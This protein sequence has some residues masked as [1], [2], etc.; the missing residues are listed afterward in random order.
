MNKYEISYIYK[1]ELR[2]K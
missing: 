2:T 1:N